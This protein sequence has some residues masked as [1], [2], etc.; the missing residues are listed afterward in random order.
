L[1]RCPARGED[2]L[3]EAFLQPHYRCF[4]FSYEFN[5]KGEIIDQ[6]PRH[7]TGRNENEAERYRR[8]AIEAVYDYQ[9]KD[10]RNTAA[11]LTYSEMD[12][13]SEICDDINA[14]ADT[15]TVKQEVIEFTKKIQARIISQI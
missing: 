4:D 13:L 7:Y 6:K 2:F 10:N 15:P 9:D 12:T 14:G 8:I 11:N 5:Y 1:Q 3:V